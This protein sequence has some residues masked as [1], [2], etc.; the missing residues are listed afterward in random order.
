MGWLAETVASRVGARL[1][2]DAERDA[3][4]NFDQVMDEVR[5]SNKLPGMNLDPQLQA[6]LRAW[7]IHDDNL[8]AWLAPTTDGGPAAKL[9]P[10]DD[11][12]GKYLTLMTDQNFAA[13]LLRNAAVT[14][15]NLR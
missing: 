14:M 6:E 11:Q 12:A 8:N 13:T 5:R 10:R 15:I 9:R 2:A 1:R 3:W 7:C 4:A